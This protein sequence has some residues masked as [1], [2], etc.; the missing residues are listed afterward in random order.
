MK[1]SLCDKSS[2]DLG[3]STSKNL[4]SVSYGKLKEIQNHTNY[5][6]IIPNPPKDILN[7]IVLTMKQKYA[8]MDLPDSFQP[9][10]SGDVGTDSGFVSTIS[11]KSTPRLQSAFSVQPK[12]GLTRGATPSDTV[13]T[14]GAGG[15]RSEQIVICSTLLTKF[16]RFNTYI[17][18][19]IQTLMHFINSLEKQA[20]YYARELNIIQT[21]LKE[22]SRFKLELITE[23]ANLKDKCTT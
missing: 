23:L 18:S 19:V 11:G 9:L 16:S 21:T 14:S 10:T 3:A 5:S 13:W 7:R 12:V 20:N 22:Y 4:Y 17:K 15:S 1:Y 6:W 8:G 2:Q